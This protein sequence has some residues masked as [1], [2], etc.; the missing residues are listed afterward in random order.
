MKKKTVIT[1]PKQL[2]LVSC[3]CISAKILPYT[4]R[5]WRGLAEAVQGLTALSLNW[6]VEY[7][8][9][10]NYSNTDF[11]SNIQLNGR[12]ALKQLEDRSMFKSK[13]GFFQNMGGIVYWGMFMWH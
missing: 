2:I 10:L 4:E 9:T 6:K 1:C 13:C 5:Q 8:L 12:V 11:Y 7:F 3:V